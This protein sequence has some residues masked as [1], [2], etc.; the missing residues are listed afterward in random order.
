M[1]ETI[2][3]VMGMVIIMI[4]VRTDGACDADC[5]GIKVRGCVRLR[6]AVSVGRKAGLVG[7]LMISSSA[8]AANGSRSTSIIRIETIH[9][10]VLR[11]MVLDPPRLGIIPAGHGR[12]SIL[13]DFRGTRASG[14]VELGI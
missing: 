5:S 14:H 9:L 1:G 13:V 11:R 7:D 3:V 4:A 8:C 6:S 10:Q 12:Q 2:I